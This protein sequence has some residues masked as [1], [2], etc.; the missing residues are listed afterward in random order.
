[1]FEW[2]REQDWCSLVNACTDQVYAT[3]FLHGNRWIVNMGF[4]DLR[5][6]H[7]TRKAAKKAVEKILKI[8]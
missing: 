3:C 6:T 1:M 8:S 5:N 4:G 2:K 7:K